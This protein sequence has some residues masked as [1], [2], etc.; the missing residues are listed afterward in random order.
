[1]KRTETATKGSAF[2]AD[3]MLFLAVLGWAVS[4]PVAKLAM[5]DWGGYKN[6]FL[7]G[8]FWLAFAI[9]GMLAL[10]NCSWQKLI[11][12]AKPGFWVGL[13]LVLVFNFQY[14]ALSIGSSGEVAFI[15]ALSSVLVPVG[16]WVVFKKRAKLGM[17]I[18]LIVAT[19]GAILVNY[20][21]SFSFDH[22]GWLAFLGAVGIAA[23]II[24]VG[25]FMGQKVGGEKKYEKVPFLTVQFLVLAAA[26][27]LLSV[28]TE[29]SAKGMPA[30]SNNAIFGMVFMAVVATAGAFFIQTKYQSITSPE[31][32]ALVFT[33][34]S[35]FAGLFGYLLLAEAFTSTMMIG[36]AL[37]F[38]GVVFAEVLAARE[39]GRGPEDPEG[40]QGTTG[41]PFAELLTVRRPAPLMAK[42]LPNLPAPSQPCHGVS[43]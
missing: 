13:T 37:I 2:F 21:G 43:E 15:T 24:L 38:V 23:Y 41:G 5:N 16:M 34:E 6:F 17:W 36:A 1:M 9:F 26:T 4:F 28:L 10:R 20:T 11:A 19:V 29:V 40:P 7:A 18:G 27:T 12:H 42:A 39:S 8:R 32:A 25:H 3:S 31:R 30:W 14:K 22:A 33:L 35:P